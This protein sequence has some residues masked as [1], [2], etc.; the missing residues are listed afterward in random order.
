MI[1]L[2]NF[3]FNNFSHCGNKKAGT[4]LELFKSVNSK[5]LLIFSKISPNCQKHSIEKIY[6]YIN[7]WVF[8]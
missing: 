1:R 8:N 4:F 5:K 3:Y 2:H 6:C 7:I